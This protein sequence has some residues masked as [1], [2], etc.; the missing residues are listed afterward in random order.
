MKRVADIKR[1]IKREKMYSTL[2]RQEGKY[3]LKK[4]KEE[5][6]ENAPESAKDSAHEAKVAFMFANKRKKIVEKEEKKLPK[7]VKKNVN[8]RKVSCS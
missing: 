6:G 7:K 2:A 4:E 5:K 1:V 8:S 3:A